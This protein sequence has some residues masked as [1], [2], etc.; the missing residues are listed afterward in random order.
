MLA[1]IV[2][3][4]LLSILKRSSNMGGGWDSRIVMAR[5]L[6]IDL[7]NLAVVFP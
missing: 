5:K 6:Y 7:S 3:A 2:T 4:E 1:S